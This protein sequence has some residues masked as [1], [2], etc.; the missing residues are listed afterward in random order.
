M[1]TI[2][3]WSTFPSNLDPPVARSLS[4]QFILQEL[5]SA[6]KA[7]KELQI[8]T[9]EQLQEAN[10]KEEISSVSKQLEKFLLF[11]LK[12][13]FSQTSSILDK[14]CFYCEILLQASRE[15]G[16]DIQLVLE[17]M[18]SPIL[19]MKS[20]LTAWQ[21]MLAPLDQTLAQLLELYADIH[22][23]LCRFFS[24]LSPF[25]KEARSD[26]NVL[27]YLIEHKEELNTFLGEKYIEGLLQSFFPAGHDQLRTA[28]HQGYNRRGFS[29]FFSKI[30]PLI[31]EIEW[32]TTSL[33]QPLLRH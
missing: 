3:P 1:R 28:I 32:E 16:L 24:A 26:E 30:E 10:L 31:N 8:T 12:N 17:S 27:I 9:P 7:L 18:R 22:Q 25:L 2:Q 5:I 6:F 29:H 19:K 14:L 21:K 4:L 23:K 15:D 20:K 13:P 11:V 33:C